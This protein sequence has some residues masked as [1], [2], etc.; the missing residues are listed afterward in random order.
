MIRI[1]TITPCFRMEKYLKRFLDDLPKQT[2]FQQLEIVLDH[3]EPTE[4]ELIWVREF[5]EKYPGHLKHIH[6]TKVDP[7]GISMNRCIKEA[8]GEY[9]AI[10]N[11]DDLRTP[12]SLQKQMEMLDGK[13]DVS[14][15]HGNFLIVNTFG[16]TNGK[17]VDHSS[18]R[19]YPKEYTRSMIVGPFFMWRKSLCEKAGLFDEQLRTGADFDLAI[20][21]AINGKPDIVHGLLGYYLD[22]GKGA[23]TRGDGLQ[24]IER[25]LIEMRYGITD[26]I[27]PELVPLVLERKYEI[28]SLVQAGKSTPVKHHV[29]NYTDFILQNSHP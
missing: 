16:A 7:I 5:Q 10:W 22:E 20:R 3:N 12:D 29:P 14:I 13:P 6:I 24:Q 9:V 8:S 1:S 19:F 28:D 17:F 23:S 21:L 2:C 27:E 18:Y 15:S 25:T 4:Q 11:V 26:K